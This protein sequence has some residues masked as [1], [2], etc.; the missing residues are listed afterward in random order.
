MSSPRQRREKTERRCLAVF[1]KTE[2]GTEVCCSHGHVRAI[3][4]TRGC[5]E[6][7]CRDEIVVVEVSRLQ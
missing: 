4:V 3:L 5:L 1:R 2:R 6:I 7:K